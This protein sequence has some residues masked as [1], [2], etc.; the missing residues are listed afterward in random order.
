MTSFGKLVSENGS[1]TDFFEKR[2]MLGTHEKN[3]F[4]S[5][6]PY[7]VFV[8]FGSARVFPQKPKV[9]EPCIERCCR[10]IAWPTTL[11]IINKQTSLIVV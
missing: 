6:P 2:F 1:E 9:G 4:A 3:L 8:F 7:S 10:R 11:S 5:L